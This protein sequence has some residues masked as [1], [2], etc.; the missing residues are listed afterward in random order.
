MRGKGADQR[1]FHK[2]MNQARISASAPSIFVKPN[3]KQPKQ[4]KTCQ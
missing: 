3:R 1:S 2:P 4:K